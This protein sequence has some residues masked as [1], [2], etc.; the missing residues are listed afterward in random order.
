MGEAKLTNS[1]MSIDRGEERCSDAVMC[2]LLV[3]DMGA[4][5]ISKFL[6]ETKVNDV[7]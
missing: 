5:V 3:G 7:D 4:V 1:V 2:V 6:C